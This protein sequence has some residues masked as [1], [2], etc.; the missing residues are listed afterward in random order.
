M[1]FACYKPIDTCIHSSN[2]QNFS[3]NF[4]LHWPTKQ[5]SRIHWLTFFSPAF[6][7]KRTSH[8]YHLLLQTLYP[9]LVVADKWFLPKTTFQPWLAQMVETILIMLIVQP[10]LMKNLKIKLTKGLIRKG[11]ELVIG[12]HPLWKVSYNCKMEG[13]LFTFSCLFTIFQDWNLQV[14]IQNT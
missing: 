8:P 7:K 12:E 9:K 14:K 13:R 6:W 3:I 11:P 10:Q 5:F 1:P 2:S 4:F